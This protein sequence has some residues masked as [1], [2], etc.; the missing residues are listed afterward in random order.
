[1]KDNFS[2]HSEA[3][4]RFRPIY[5]PG[6]VAWLCKLPPKRNTLW[7][8]ATGNGQLALALAP[9]FEQV[10]AT[11]I[12]KNQ[13]ANAL[14]LP[15]VTYSVQAAEQTDI[16][17][18]SV[19]MITVA[20]AIHWFNFEHFYAEVRRVAKENAVL[21]VV[22]YGLIRINDRLNTL[23]DT[24]YKETTGPYWDA[25]R[26]Y[27][28]EAYRSIPFPFEEI[29]APEFRMCFRWNVQQLLGYLE[30][31]SAVQHYKHAKQEDPMLHIRNALLA[32][33]GEN[34]LLD[35]E[36]PLF[37]RVGRV[38]GEEGRGMRMEG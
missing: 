28:D 32:A 15:N 9:Y 22:G 6:L 19:D 38:G 31:W 33:W 20:Q 13:L 1:M 27:I 17:T 16:E 35:V 30:T 2:A 37:L 14:Q 29:Q 11:D 3:Y 34:I 12:S 18:G 5:P 10:L 26:R 25:E 21:A 8:C 24:F 36:F 4:A 7:D 23:I